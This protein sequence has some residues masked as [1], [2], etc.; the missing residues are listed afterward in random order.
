MK[1]I[2]HRGNLE[3]P[4]KE[5]ENEPNYILHAL[6][7]GFDVEVDVWCIN[8]VFFLGHDEPIYE[9]DETFLEN[10]KIWCHSK[11]IESLEK[12]LENKKIHFFWHQ[13]DSFTITSK[14]II[15]T[16][17]GNKLTKNSICVLPERSNYSKD[18]IKKCFG[19]CSD[20]IRNYD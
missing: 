7:N 4:N 16:F 3:G 15:W 13:E 17:P 10:E 12:M 5:K 14:N 6:S 9:I 8:G 18:E 2:S 19:V 1:L 11:N 20:Y